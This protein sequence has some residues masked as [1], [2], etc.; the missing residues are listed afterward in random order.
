MEMNY[1]K[2]FSKETKILISDM[3][4]YTLSHRD[5]KNFLFPVF[6]YKVVLPNLTKKELNF[7][8]KTIL[9]ILSFQNADSAFISKKLLLNEDLVKYIFN[10]LNEAGYYK[11]GLVTEAG[12]KA[13][14]N[15]YEPS[16]TIIGY[17]IYDLLCERLMD[18][19]ILEN[20]LESM[21]IEHSFYNGDS[22]TLQKKISEKGYRAY[23][24]KTV[25][26]EINE[27][28]IQNED[29]YKSYM[30]Y[31]KNY[32]EYFIQDV[33]SMADSSIINKIDNKIAIDKIK[34]ISTKP[35]PYY[36]TTY[37]YYNS[38]NVNRGI[39]ASDPFFEKVYFHLKDFIENYKN[40]YNNIREMYTQL[41]PSKISDLDIVKESEEKIKEFEEVIYNIFEKDFITNHKKLIGESFYNL[42]NSYRLLNPND[43][44]T[45]N[46]GT[47]MKSQEDFI[48]C[49]NKA[50]EYIFHYSIFNMG[51][52][53][54]VNNILSSD[55][56]V[57]TKVLT[58][59]ALDIGFD[60][61]NNVIESF[62]YKKVYKGRI[63]SKSGILKGD[64]EDIISLTAV[65]LLISLNNSNCNFADL[66]NGYDN[67][68]SIL[69][70]INNIR[71][72]KYHD[73]FK[74]LNNEEIKKYF[75][76]FLGIFSILFY[77]NINY[78]YFSDIDKNDKKAQNYEDYKNEL[79]L[80]SDEVIDILGNDVKNYP[81]LFEY[82]VS[83][84]YNNNN[85]ADVYI[86]IAK[87][88][89]NILKII[90]EQLGTENV[91]YFVREELRK[92]D[93]SFID[94]IESYLLSIGF[95]M[96]NKFPE[97]LLDRWKKNN[98]YKITLKKYQVFSDLLMII[99]IYS[100][101]NPDDILK[102][103]SKAEPNFINYSLRY[104]IRHHNTALS[105]DR[106]ILNFD[107]YKYAVDKTY[108]C[109]KAV[110]DIIKNN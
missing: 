3:V 99:I 87:I 62:F 102:K 65:N 63:F 69:L 16:E 72:T 29:I 35:I 77:T 100:K 58:K 75:Q 82:L 33:Q 90:I 46:V 8:Q 2:M 49:L 18:Y 81:A 105:N 74:N 23:I 11:N 51:N 15:I 17:C 21:Q 109:V 37:L 48:E 14:K 60:N 73:N 1:D 53:I 32:K 80:A 5:K 86:K 96:N 9:E 45:S 85:N 71:V 98:V 10:E 66:V 28:E 103:I 83:M 42:F 40:R 76:Y 34:I 95:N 47:K 4:K 78:K 12:K 25:N 50:F 84:Q 26:D 59:I 52:N 24:I 6:L 108:S 92:D 27:I 97:F 94:D 19:F 89:E 107:N 13:L 61:E 7:F 64:I 30:N 67:L 101:L 55:L 22:V 36:L 57:N 20:D 54:K 43:P 104:G 31:I 41:S 68:F 79:L 93:K 110:I 44:E 56:N 70:E 39:L 88:F 106:H 38:S 91:F